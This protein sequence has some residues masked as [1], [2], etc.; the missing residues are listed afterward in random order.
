MTILILGP[1]GS[2]KSVCAEKLAARLSDG[3]LYYI[4]TML[5]YGEDGRIRVEKHRQQRADAGFITIERL[6]HVSAIP[7]PPDAVALL[8]DVSNLLGN[9]LFGGERDGNIGGVYADITAM[10][11]KCRAS[12]LV[13]I[14]GLAAQSEHDGETR[15]Y[16]DALNRLN[17]KLF[18][19]AD[20]VI[21][22]RDGTPIFL[23]GDASAP[24]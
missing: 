24:D 20:A 21:A 12:V 9:A 18:E 15:D 6:N 19:F 10:C 13:S 3:A 4:A 16:I 17:G 22:M 1:N 14:D 7:L 23:K 2:G 8:E 11:A 5:P